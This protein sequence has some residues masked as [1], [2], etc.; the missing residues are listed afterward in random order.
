MNKAKK[1]AFEVMIKFIKENPEAGIIRNDFSD[2]DWEYLKSRIPDL[3][4]RPTFENDFPVIDEKDL[5]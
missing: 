5:N 4:L 1:E 2:K 3:D